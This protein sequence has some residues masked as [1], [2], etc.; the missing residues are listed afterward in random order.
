MA[1]V[2]AGHT[3]F[4]V[5]NQTGNRLVR[6]LLRSPAHALVSRRL[7]L[8]TVT[9]RRSGKRFTFPVGYQQDGDEVTIGVEWPQRKVWWRNLRGEGAPVTM[10]LRGTERRGH[11]RASEGEAGEVKVRVQLEPA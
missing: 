11:A 5:F 4:A 2:P 10:R 7:A 3:P 8:V 9:G 6:G 1:I